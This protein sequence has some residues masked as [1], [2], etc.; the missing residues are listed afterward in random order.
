MRHINPL[1]AY[2][3]ILSIIQPARIQDIEKY[4]ATYLGEELTEWLN[5]NS[6]LRE[7]HEVARASK[8][9]TDVRK[10]VYFLTPSGRQIPRHAGLERSVDNRRLFLMKA[11][12]KVYK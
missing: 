12:R 7:A 6:K 11:Q 5:K 4:S 2:L 1:F 8:L 3:S 9:V 10:G